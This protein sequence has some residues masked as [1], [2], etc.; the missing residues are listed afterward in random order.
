MGLRTAWTDLWRRLGAA[1]DPHAVY[2]DLQHRYDEPE[3][4]Y[5]TLDHIAHCLAEL[6]EVGEPAADLDAI[7][8]AL[9][10][11]DSIY[12]SRANDNEEC[13]AELAR[14]VIRA[15]G[16]P[17]PFG[18]TV[19]DLILAT[20]HT[21]PPA[22]LNQQILVDIDLAIL[23]QGRERFDAYEQEIRAEYSWAAPEAF[24]HGRAAV[25]ASILARPRI[26]S[27][28]QFWRKYEASARANLA[29]AIGRWTVG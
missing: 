22:T 1:G 26:Y 3:R 18:A 29:Y 19:T 23:G 21:E 9:W 6:R 11:H 2:Q 20:K 10:F 24:A 25:L 16:L 14:Q 8:F 17:E 7:E 12:Y 13:S 4:A 15:A 27:T 28:D 5:H